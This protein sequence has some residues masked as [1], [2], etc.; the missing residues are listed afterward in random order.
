M[1]CRRLAYTVVGD[2][3]FCARCAADE[4]FQAEVRGRGPCVRCHG[5]SGYANQAAHVIK[6]GYYA[7]RWDPR[8][9]HPLCLACHKW[10]TEHPLEGEDFWRAFLG[11]ELYDG[12]KFSA[13]HES[14]MDP[15]NVIAR[16][17]PLDMSKG[18]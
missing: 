4:L 1:K 16:L 7:V 12:L 11:D 18:K 15:K 9:C 17:A 3:R 6:R 13:K 8:N 14:P 10:E 5:E 2:K